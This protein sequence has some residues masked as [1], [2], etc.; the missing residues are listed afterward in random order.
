MKVNNGQSSLFS[1]GIKNE[2]KNTDN[3]NESSTIQDM[4]NENDTQI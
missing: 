3:E 2:K 4:T 1:F